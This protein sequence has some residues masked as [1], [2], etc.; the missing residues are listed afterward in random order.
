MNI[1]E[2]LDTVGIW[3]VTVTLGYILTG[4]INQLGLEGAPINYSIIMM[5]LALM[6]VPGY[7]SL[8]EYRENGNWKNLNVIWSVLIIIGVLA[9]ISGQLTVTGDLLRYSYYQKWFILPAVLFAYTAYK[10]NGF[11]RSVYTIATLLN[12]AAAFSLS[13]NPLLQSYAFFTAALIQGIPML[14]DWY[15]FNM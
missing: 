2:R 9:N 15:H 5:W 7:Y 8:R 1:L 14:A 3:G 12:L 13:Q 4:I 6:A 10:M 11:S